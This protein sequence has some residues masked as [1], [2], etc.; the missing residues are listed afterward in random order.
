MKFHFPNYH[1]NFEDEDDA[2][3]GCVTDYI[4]KVKR[5][6]LQRPVSSWGSNL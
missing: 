5:L 1:K 3:I 2:P 4:K 6:L